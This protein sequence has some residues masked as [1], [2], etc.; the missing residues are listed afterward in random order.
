MIKYLEKP[1]HIREIIPLALLELAKEIGKN[2][3]KI[4]GEIIENAKKEKVNAN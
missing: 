4:N 3:D 2:R 1:M